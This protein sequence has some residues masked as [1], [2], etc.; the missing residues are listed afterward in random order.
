MISKW[1]EIVPGT[2][3]FTVTI[4]RTYLRAATIKEWKKV[5]QDDADEP[6]DYVETEALQEFNDTILEQTIPGLDIAAVIK[7]V[8]GL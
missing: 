1:G 4:R 5:H 8:N 7:A 6:Y 2:E 3:Q